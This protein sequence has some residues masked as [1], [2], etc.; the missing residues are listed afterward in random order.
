M[1]AQEKLIKLM[2]I[3]RGKAW[4]AIS[5]FCVGFVQTGFAQDW[6]GQQVEQSAASINTPSRIPLH[7]ALELYFPA[8]YQFNSDG[9]DLSTDILYDASLPWMEA[10]NKGLASAG[11]EMQTNLFK[12]I[13]VIKKSKA[14][15]GNTVSAVNAV[16]K[17]NAS[18]TV[19]VNTT[20]TTNTTTVSSTLIP[21][22]IQH[23]LVKYVPGDYGISV[24]NEIDTKTMISYDTTLP[25]LEALGKGLTAVGLDV[26]ANMYQ[27]NITVTLFQKPLQ[28]SKLTRSSSSIQEWNV[29]KDDKTIRAVLERWAAAAGWNIA[30]EVPR[31]VPVAFDA[32]FFGS[33]EVAVDKLM[34]S[35]RGSDYPLVNCQYEDNKVVRILRRG[36]IKKCEE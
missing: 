33:F 1:L 11:L 21:I 34:R 12:R 27:K 10:F 36:E 28:L 30:W 8:N 2:F 13:V 22:S 26:S 16:S 20:N 32:T 24:A 25:W 3:C 35:L 29:R 18:N 19:N 9:V 4:I 6:H 31:K 7:Q 17:V 23:A 5:M 14:G 15:V